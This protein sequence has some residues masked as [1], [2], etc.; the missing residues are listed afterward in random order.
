M[1]RK[2]LRRVD[3]VGEVLY[4]ASTRYAF[5]RH[6]GRSM[7]PRLPTK[8]VLSIRTDCESFY[9]GDLVAVNDPETGEVVVRS[10]SAVPGTEMVNRL[11]GGRPPSF[12][13][14]ENQYWV[15]AVQDGER[16]SSVFGPIDGSQI[17]G[18]ALY[19]SIIKAPINNSEDAFSDDWETSWM[20][21]ILPQS[22]QDLQ[23]LWR[24]TADSSWME[25]A[26]EYRQE[27]PRD[28]G[29]FSS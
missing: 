5:V 1:L 28:L 2:F 6:S 21:P 10:V 27:L 22:F 17:V 24:K 13:L 3:L 26:D 15:K 11:P 4:T 20:L 19:C 8:S 7:A 9:T 25:R 29:S 18:R 16:D 14:S 23:T 12:V